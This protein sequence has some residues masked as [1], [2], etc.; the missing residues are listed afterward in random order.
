M[1]LTSKIS[2]G[3]QAGSGFQVGN[4]PTSGKGGYDACITDYLA[5]H[6]TAQSSAYLEVRTWS[7]H[8]RM[9]R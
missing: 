2:I 6:L 1:I 9:G 5:F 4:C 8:S 3:G 7:M